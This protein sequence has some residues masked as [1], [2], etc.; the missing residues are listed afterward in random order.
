MTTTHTRPDP[1]T[2]NGGQRPPR[3][4]RGYTPPL[5]ALIDAYLAARRSG[6]THTAAAFASLIRNHPERTRA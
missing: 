5:S 4:D 3:V 6:Y 2:I 1:L